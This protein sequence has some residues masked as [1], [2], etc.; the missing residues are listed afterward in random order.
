MGFIIKLIVKTAL[1]GGALY[2]ARIYVPGFLLVGG[3]DTLA[4]G[5]LVLA[6]LNTFVRPILRVIST[7]LLWITFGLFNIVIH[8]AILWI[9][10]QLLTQLTITNF[11]G[12]FW[13]AIIVAIANIFI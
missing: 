4:I 5:G 11:W 2:I 6:I 8:I 1:N 10:D 7:P 9:A 12:L 3:L 13:A